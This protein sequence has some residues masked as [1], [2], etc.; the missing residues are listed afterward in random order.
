M[1]R[2]SHDAGNLVEPSAQ[3]EPS[4]RNGETQLTLGAFQDT[5]ENSRVAREQRISQLRLLWE[6]RSFLL[7]MFVCGM[8]ASLMVALLIPN[9]YEA[10]ER[11]M[12]PDSQSGMGAALLTALSGRGT[13]ASSAAGAV[14]GDF[15]GVKSSGAL[16]VGILESRTVKD[17]LIEQF[18]LK[19]VYHQSEVEDARNQLAN[20]TNVSEDRKNGIISIRVTDRDAHRA[21]AIAQA[22]VSELDRLVVQVS[23]S[24]AR[25]ERI[26]LE[27]RLKAVKQELDSAAHQFSDFASKNT[28]IDV[29][30]QGKAMVE[31]AAVLQGQLIAAESELSGLEAIYT[32]Q[33]VRVRALRARIAE[34]HS[35]LGKMGGDAN[36]PMSSSAKNDPAAYPTIR[37]L[38]VLGVTYANLYRQT[39]IE[40]TVYE[41]LTQQYELAKVQEA[42]EI[43]SVKVLDA[44]VV[45]TKKVFPHRLTLIAASTF[46]WLSLCCAWL[47]AKERWTEIDHKDP[48]KQFV[49]EV[50]QTLVA[51]ARRFVPEGSLLHNMLSRNGS[52]PSSVG[53]ASEPA[54][55]QPEKA[56]EA[57]RVASNST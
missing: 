20:S 51:D 43:P 11:L 12:P 15:L 52:Q 48:R 42:K 26:F 22:Y 17:R 14:T 50:M 25:R 28:A 2:N 3:R 27:E 6:N 5:G 44:A 13:G 41:L 47:F 7:R 18:D 32:D 38:P 40:E 8:A 35:Q 10:V 24:S 53:S 23:T 34:L 31:A 4:S 39:K 30:A 57:A 21:A 55:T 19:K 45:P 33:N 49:H 36:A 9:R 54:S 29:P 1:A 56:S 16:F 37:Q 46:V